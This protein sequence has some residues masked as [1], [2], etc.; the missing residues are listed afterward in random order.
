M[1]LLVNDILDYLEDEGVIGGATGW[2]G[3]FGYMP[4]DPDKVI[5]VFES[6]GDPPEKAQPGSDEI[7]YDLPGFQIRG[8]GAKFGYE[9]LRT[10]MGEVYRALHGSSLAPATGEPAYIDV[11]AVQSGPLPMG[12]DNNSRPELTWNFRCMRERETT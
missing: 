1:T 6:V 3:A 10:K 11:L 12:M 7:E 4:P 2:T 5:V 9:A 8:R